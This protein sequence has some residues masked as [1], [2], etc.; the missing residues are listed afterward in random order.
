MRFA[1]ASPLHDLLGM[2]SFELQEELE[3]FTTRFSDSVSQATSA[4]ERSERPEVSEEALRKSLRYISSALEIASGLAPGVNLLDMIAFV[5]LC[6]SVLETHMLDGE[7][8]AEL[9]RAFAT[10][11]SELA[12][13]ASRALAP[14]QYA[15]V[16]AVADSWLGANPEH[17]HVEG[18]RLADFSAEAG[19]AAAGRAAQARGL[20]GSVKT[21][22]HTANQAMVL[23]ERALFLLH[24]MPFLW[25]LQARLAVR[26]MVRDTLAQLTVGPTAPIARIAHMARRG[27][28]VA[29]A[30]V[31]VGAVMWL[32]R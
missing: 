27:L 2:D 22:T 5:H 23:G 7:G 8:S 19:S 28:L 18:V 31:T 17:T 21:A 1:S 11:E 32:R 16:I 20:L 26:E 13:I 4:L 14:N 25:R 10:A 9:S 29:G 24:R 6:R 30:L 12:E 3:R 15:Q